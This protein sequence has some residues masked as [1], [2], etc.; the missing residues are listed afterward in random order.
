MKSEEEKSAELFIAMSVDF[1]QGKINLEHYANTLN[2]VNEK[3]Q[4]MVYEDLTRQAE[5]EMDD[6]GC[7]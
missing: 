6:F 1:L 2:M 7:L 5:S 3:F 4:N